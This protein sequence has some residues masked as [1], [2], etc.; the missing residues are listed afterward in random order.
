MR[1]KVV[2]GWPGGDLARAV[3]GFF[4]KFSL[5]FFLL[6]E[7]EPLIL[8]HNQLFLPPLAEKVLGVLGLLRDADEFLLKGLL[9][10]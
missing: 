4:E 7:E 10:L 3:A 9:R 6:R 8:A 5:K 2:E 1:F